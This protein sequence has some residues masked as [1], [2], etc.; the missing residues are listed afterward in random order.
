MSLC[1]QGAE[2]I[3]GD[4]DLRKTVVVRNVARRGEIASAEGR[5][6]GMFLISSVSQLLFLACSV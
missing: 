4:A 2:S 1:T 6:G 3:C 5:E